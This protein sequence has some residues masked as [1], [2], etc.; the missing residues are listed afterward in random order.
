MYNYNFSSNAT[1][2]IHFVG[3]GHTI[4]VFIEIIFMIIQIIAIWR[5]F[6]KAGKAGWKSIIPIYNLVILFK[7]SKL[8]PWLLLIYLSL[9]IPVIGLVASIIL[10]V[11]QANGLSKAFGKSTG[12][13]IGLLLL[14][15]VFYVILG[16]GSS[17]YIGK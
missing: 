8:S 12:F 16:F 2:G 15:F 11:V 13:T 3:V 17:R 10:K 5:I 7:I 14:P 6:D 1:A 9:L 4:G